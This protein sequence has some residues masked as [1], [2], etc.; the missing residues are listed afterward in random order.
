MCVFLCD[1]N[2]LRRIK[3]RISFIFFFAQ[4]DIIS[5][6]F[7]ELNRG[8]IYENFFCEI[9]IMCACG[10]GRLDVGNNKSSM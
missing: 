8:E 1:S 7:H 4:D 10:R 2:R 9:D 3:K 5:F 6:V